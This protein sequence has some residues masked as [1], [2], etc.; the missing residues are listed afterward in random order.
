MAKSTA[1]TVGGYLAG[2]SPER[3]VAIDVVRENLPV[4]YAEQTEAVVQADL[5]RP[6][7]LAGV[8]EGIDVV[9]SCAGQSVS[10]RPKNSRASFTGVDYRPANCSAYLACSPRRTWA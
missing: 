8:C 3:R 2:L 10:P 1:T 9:F 4:S 7:S 6:N 5:S